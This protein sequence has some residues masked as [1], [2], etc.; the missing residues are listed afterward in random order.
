MELRTC[1]VTS[2]EFATPPRLAGGEFGKVV[3]GWL[4]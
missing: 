4:R 2:A 1:E 3:G